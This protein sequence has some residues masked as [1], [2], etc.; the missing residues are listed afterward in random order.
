MQP[1]LRQRQLSE[2]DHGVSEQPEPQAQAPQVEIVRAGPEHV[3]AIAALAAATGFVFG[4]DSQTSG[5]V[6]ADLAI[7]I[8][9]IGLGSSLAFSQMLRW[10]RRYLLARKAAVIELEEMLAWHGGTR[11]VG[12]ELT[13]PGNSWLRSSPTG[14]IMMLLPVLVAVCWVAIMILVAVS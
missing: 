2:R 13:D 8:A 10:G 9:V 5:Q 12:R 11:I 14:L 4:G 1:L 3:A 7:V 6:N